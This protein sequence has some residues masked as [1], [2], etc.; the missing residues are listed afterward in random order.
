ML[1]LHFSSSLDCP[2]LDHRDFEGARM[3]LEE[4][5]HVVDRHAGLEILLPLG[6]SRRVIILL[7]EQPFVVSSLLHEVLLCYLVVIYSWRF[8]VEEQGPGGV[9]RRKFELLMVVL[10]VVDQG[11]LYLNYGL[12]LL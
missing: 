5:K 3:C 9:R 1:L 11:R 12:S 2:E 7:Y 10:Q 4:F 6:L 8:S